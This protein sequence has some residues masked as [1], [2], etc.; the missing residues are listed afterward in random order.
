M[1]THVTCNY[2]RNNKLYPSY[3]SRQ[4]VFVNVKRVFLSWGATLVHPTRLKAKIPILINLWT[5]TLPPYNYCSS[6]LLKVSEEESN[7]GIVS[8]QGFLSQKFRYT[9]LS[10]HISPSAK[11]SRV[12]TAEEGWGWHLPG[13]QDYRTFN[14]LRLHNPFNSVRTEELKWTHKCTLYES[15]ENQTFVLLNS[16]ECTHVTPFCFTICL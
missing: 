2:S 10:L 8:L 1:I 13:L 7:N 11:A 4:S 6:A 9:N 5:R 16:V 12:M 14:Y 15:Q 3:N